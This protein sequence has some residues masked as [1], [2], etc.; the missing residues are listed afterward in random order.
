[1]MNLDGGDAVVAVAT[2]NG[3]KVDAQNGSDEESD[4]EGEEPLTQDTVEAEE[5]TLDGLDVAEEE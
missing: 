2:T 1:M 3:K 4:A 5:G